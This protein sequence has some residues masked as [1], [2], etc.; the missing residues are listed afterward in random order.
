MAS[1][2]HRILI[3][4][5]CYNV[6]D[7]VTLTIRK[8]EE[9]ILAAGHHVCIVS[10]DSGDSKNT[11]L[12]PQHPNRTVIFL[13]NSVPIP[14]LHDPHNPDNSYSLGFSLGRST[15]QKIMDF[16][17]SLIH[18]TAPD[19]TCL[20]M[21]QYARDMEIP[22]MGTYHSNIPEYMDHYPGLGW[23]KFILAAFFR[24]QYN[25]LQALY[26]PTPYIH[27]QLCESSKMDRVTDLGVWGRGIDL[28]KFSPVHR[29]RK[30]R[31]KFGFDDHDVVICWVGRLVPEKRPDIY[32]KVVRRL[33]AKNIPFKGLVIG[34]GPSEDTMKALP[35]TVY[36]GWMSGDEL[37][38]AYASSDI[39]LF[40][41]GVETF[42]N[43]TLEAAASGLPIVVE[44]GCSGHLVQHGKNGFACADGEVDGFFDATL[45]LVLDDERRLAMSE[46]SRRFAMQFEKS[47]VC[48]RMLTNYSKVTD[49]FYTEFG[50]H[51]ANR[52]R[53]YKK[54]H[55]FLAGNYPRP[56]LMQFLEYLFVKLFQVMYHMITIFMHVREAFPL[57]AAASAAISSSSKPATATKRS[58]TT[59]QAVEE[60]RPLVRSQESTAAL[61][62]IAEVEEISDSDTEHGSQS[63]SMDSVE[64]EDK[65]AESL[66]ET[67]ISTITTRSRDEE[68]APSTVC[69]S[70]RNKGDIFVSHI[71]TKMLISCFHWQFHTECQV[72]D[73][74]TY[75]MSPSEWT[76]VARKRK[77]S[78]E[79]VV[80]GDE[81]KQ[82]SDNMRTR[83][84]QS[85][86]AEV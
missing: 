14:F 41:S 18:V 9:Q 85:F 15:K 60:R 75:A 46:E 22:L 13:E 58:Q 50:G 77:N 52:D 16:E 63:S 33:A 29:S 67:T 28:A 79:V 43:V 49:Q 3:Y 48:R 82:R 30:F 47:V 40:P 20:H 53:E 81:T 31:E 27:R 54:E 61:G 7:G 64:M 8:I 78:G 73:G 26:V 24:H 2:Q 4:T 1:H 56:F 39:F 37:S 68:P 12:V 21:I 69:C 80:E 57:P 11:H 17:P 44:E 32:E 71:I 35:N 36:A 19:C 5:T 65:D 23:L 45:C 55:S 6:I 25:F 83:G 10:T 72:R 51:H 86:A 62:S 76:T 74:I 59:A 34:A 66:T 84:S 70:R 38:A 42:G